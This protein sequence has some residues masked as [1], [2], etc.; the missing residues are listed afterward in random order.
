MS[1]VNCLWT[2]VTDFVYMRNGVSDRDKQSNK[3]F[4]NDTILQGWEG[5]ECE[6]ISV[7]CDTIYRPCVTWFTITIAVVGP[8]FFCVL[9]SFFPKFKRLALTLDFQSEGSSVT[10]R[11]SYS[12]YRRTSTSVPGYRLPCRNW[13]RLFRYYEWYTSP[14]LPRVP[15]TLLTPFIMTFFSYPSLGIP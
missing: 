5:L 8:H 2:T 1:F 4:R 15:C 14:V 12:F 10:T 11:T 13:H 9:G 7:S 3:L 6:V